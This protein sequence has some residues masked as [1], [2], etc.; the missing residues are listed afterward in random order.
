M[1]VPSAVVALGHGDVYMM[2]DKAV[3]KD[4][5]RHDYALRHCAGARKYTGLPRTYYEALKAQCGP[6]FESAYSL[7]FSDI[8]ENDSESPE[9]RFCSPHIG[10]H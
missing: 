2:S 6:N 10:L 8:V 9:L 4:W 3:G 1:A 7:T 5:K